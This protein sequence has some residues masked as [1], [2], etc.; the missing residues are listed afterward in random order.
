MHSARVIRGGK[1]YF[2]APG[3]SDTHIYLRAR[4]GTQEMGSQNQSAR[5]IEK[6]LET[7][8]LVLYYLNST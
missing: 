7:L 8:F 3:L 1:I 5:L 4:S 6:Q 2:K